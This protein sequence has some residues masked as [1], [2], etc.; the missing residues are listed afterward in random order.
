MLFSWSCDYRPQEPPNM[1]AGT[2]LRS[3]QKQHA[4][5]A[6]GPLSSTPTPT[7]KL[8]LLFF[9]YGPLKPAWV[10]P[11]LGR[12]WAPAGESGRSSTQLQ[13]QC[14]GSSR[15]S[16]HFSELVPAHWENQ[17]SSGTAVDNVQEQGCGRPRIW[18]EKQMAQ[19]NPLFLA[20]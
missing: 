8:S 18:T 17:H 4:L 3:L 10:S 19:A 16:L 9:P 2:V 11:S 12:L 13:P 1:G 6:T 7:L 20:S 15:M 14:T 5:L